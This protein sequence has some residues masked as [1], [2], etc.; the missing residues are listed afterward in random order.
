MKTA[1]AG[2]PDNL[3]NLGT[4]FALLELID[5]VVAVKLGQQF[6]STRPK[7]EGGRHLR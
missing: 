4:C 5:A 2:K 3:G 6:A 1:S 7:L